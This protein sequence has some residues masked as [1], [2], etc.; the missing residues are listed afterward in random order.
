MIGDLWSSS[1]GQIAG[2]IGGRGMYASTSGSYDP[3]GADAGPLAGG[4]AVRIDSGYTYSAGGAATIGGGGGP[5]VFQTGTF[6]QLGGRGGDGL[7]IFQY[8]P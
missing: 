4:G 8:I 1:L 5:C 3:S 2:S 7:V 6:G